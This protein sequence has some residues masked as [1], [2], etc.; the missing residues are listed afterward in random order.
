MLKIGLFGAAGHMGQAIRRAAQER[1][2]LVLAPLI[3]P[4]FEAETPAA[5][6]D[7]FID[8]S[9]AQAAIF[10]AARC[11]EENVPLV[12][13]V[14]GG[15]AAERETAL[16]AAAE[17]IPVLACANLLQSVVT[18]RRLTRLAARELPTFTPALIERHHARKKDAPSGTSKLL[19]ADAGAKETDVLS[20]RAG[21]IAGEH[22]ITFYG[23]GES[24]TLLHRLDGRDALA[25]AALRAAERL[26]L[27]APG[28]YAVEDM[29]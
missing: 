23:R 29:P 16:L 10:H 6:P 20:V 26:V 4:A 5:P 3:D 9:T 27:C 8:V 13:C 28:L 17:R 1:D 19:A 21:S 11:A 25:R 15:D 24:L 14:T 7:V 2:D 22:E 18:L 12:C